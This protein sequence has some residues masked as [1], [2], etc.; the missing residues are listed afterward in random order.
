MKCY[1][2]VSNLEEGDFRSLFLYSCAKEKELMHE[3]FVYLKGKPYMN[4]NHELGLNLWLPLIMNKVMY[5]HDMIYE[6][7]V[8]RIKSD[9]SSIRNRPLNLKKEGQVLNVKIGTL[10]KLLRVTLVCIHIDWFDL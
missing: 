9:A 3:R 5:M 1:L 2:N 6:C 8:Q 4:V 10:S 7:V